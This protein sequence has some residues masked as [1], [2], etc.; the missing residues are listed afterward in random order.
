MLSDETVAYIQEMHDEKKLPLK[1]YVYADFHREL[2]N[3]NFIK[4]EPF[5]GLSN[6]EEIDFAENRQINRISLL[7]AEDIAKELND[8]LI[9]IPSSIHEV[10]IVPE[11]K[12]TDVKSL[13]SL[14]ADVNRNELEWEDILSDHAYYYSVNSGYACV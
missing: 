13:N 9:I 5:G 11:D 6:I 10:I 14:I 1:F 12:V 4:G 7:S 2:A 3:V 8:D